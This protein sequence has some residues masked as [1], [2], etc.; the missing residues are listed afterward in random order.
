[1]IA[2]GINHRW[3]SLVFVTMAERAPAS[4]REVGLVRLIGR[5]SRRQ[6]RMKNPQVG[7][8]LYGEMHR[9]VRSAVHGYRMSLAT[10][11]VIA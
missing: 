7:L 1:M 5:E 9:G 6:A 3:S 8:V 11:V 10:A 4:N 2:V